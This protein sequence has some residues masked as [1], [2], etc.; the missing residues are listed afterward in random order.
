MTTHCMVIDK[1]A[2]AAADALQYIN[3]ETRTWTTEGF[4]NAL[5]ALSAAGY[6]PT[7]IVYCGGQGGD[8]GTRALAMNLYSAQFTNPE[9]TAYTMN[10]EAGIQGIQKLADLVNDGVLNADPAIVA[11]DEIALFC[12]GTAKM[13]FCW[14]AS[15]AV[16][17][18]ASIAE[19]IEPLP[20]AFPS[21]DGVPEL[22]GGIW[23][24]GIFDNGDDARVAAAKEFIKFVCD[25]EAQGPQSVYATG[26]FPVRASFGDI[27]TGTEK[28]ENA[29]FAV[30]MPFLGDY[31]NVTSGWAT[32]RTEWWNMLQ[33]VFAGGDVATEVNAY[34]DA[35]NASITK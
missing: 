23:G 26:F 22:A 9:H 3:E 11:G 7:G 19:G 35:A 8:Q 13:S 18:K 21:D 27:Y 20:M 25:D 32:Q 16:S 29:E 17:N 24:F 4:E 28:A 34:V 33:R 5:K 2:F 10:S 14:N 30:F 12:N 1:A 31:Y 15:A 6:N